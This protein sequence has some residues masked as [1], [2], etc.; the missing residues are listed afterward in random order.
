MAESAVLEI[1]GQDR[2]SRST[3]ER[4]DGNF[5]V[6]QGDATILDNYLILKNKE[7]MFQGDP[8]KL[9]AVQKELAQCQSIVDTLLEVHPGIQPLMDELLNIH[10]QLWDIEDRKRVI[11]QGEESTAMITR[12]TDPSNAPLLVEYLTLARD[13]SRLN[14]IRAQLKRRM[15]T[16]TGS[17]IVEVK[18]HRTVK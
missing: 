9:R 4:R 2:S 1:P 14:D 3:A 11:E 15:N 12:L 5:V 6:P 17:Q 18:S 7:Q 10:R 13:V 8:E 16:M